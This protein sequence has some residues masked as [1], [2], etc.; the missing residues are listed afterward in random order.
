MNKT[1]IAALLAL[2]TLA[3]IPE[4]RAD[5]VSD[6]VYLTT[7]SSSACGTASLGFKR[8]KQLPDGTSTAESSEFVVPNG[9]YLEI[10]SVEYTPPY[11]SAWAKFY[12]QF[13][14]VAI[15]PRSGA[16]GSATVLNASW[17][18][19]TIYGTNGSTADDYSEIGEIVQAGAQTHTVT[20]PVGPLM[21]SAGRLCTNAT[22]NNFWIYGGSVAVRGLLIPTGSIVA[23]TTTSSTA[24]P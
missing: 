16:A 11:S 2:P 13:I 21:S 4:A 8:I 15:R 24:S 12:Q 23:T 14:S 7:M 6:R 5:V 3:S 19:P 1:L 10:T 20:F 18:N 22:S 9:M 17:Q